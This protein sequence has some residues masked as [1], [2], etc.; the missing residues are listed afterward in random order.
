MRT[1]QRPRRAV[2]P[3]TLALARPFFRYSWSRRAF[4]LRVVGERRGPVLVRADET[5]GLRRAPV[6]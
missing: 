2:S 6:D 5:R 3:F 1:M 4:I